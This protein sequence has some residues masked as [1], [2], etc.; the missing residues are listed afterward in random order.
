MSRKSSCIQSTALLERICIT[1][2]SYSLFPPRHRYLR[3]LRLTERR[4][5]FQTWKAIALILMSA[6]L[7]LP[8]L[9][10]FSGRWGPIWGP[11][12]TQAVMTWP[13]VF[14]TS[15]DISRRALDTIAKRDIRSFSLYAFLAL[16][17]SVPLTVFLNI[18]EQ[19]LGRYFQPFIGV[20]WSRFSIFVY[21][22]IFALFVDHLPINRSKS[23]NL[24]LVV[25][26]VVP[27]V[28]FVLS[29]PHVITGVNTGLLGRLP[30]EYTYLDR[31]ESITGM[32]TVVENSQH[33]YRILKCDHSILGGLWTGIKRK[34]LSDRGV[35]GQD[36]E[37][38]SVDE[39]ESVYSA[40][41][42]QEAVRLVQRPL[43]QD[44]ALIMYPPLRFH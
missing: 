19:F 27:I 29:R 11:I 3:S 22:G 2:M 10:R 34:E 43:K 37:K 4:V 1:P 14:F 39:A 17:T 6:P 21:L 15:H 18:S 36:L 5:Q 31:R 20:L 35:V 42:V 30:S 33:G 25:A 7:I 23:T 38:R 9:F 24:A 13:C 16:S 44:T 32:I 40:F 8:T 26:V 41:V 28:V 12:L